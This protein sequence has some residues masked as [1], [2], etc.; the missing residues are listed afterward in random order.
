MA[1]CGY[2]VVTKVCARVNRKPCMF[3]QTVV[4]YRS[5]IWYLGGGLQTAVTEKITVRIFERQITRNNSRMITI[6]II[7]LRPPPP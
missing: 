3:G 5:L 4:F 1:G 7:R 2:Q 6:R